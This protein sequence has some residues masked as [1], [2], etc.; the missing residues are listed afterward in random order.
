MMCNQAIPLPYLWMIYHQISF[1]N[2]GVAISQSSTATTQTEIPLVGVTKWQCENKLILNYFLIS[3][4]LSELSAICLCVAQLI[5]PT[6]SL[7]S[8]KLTPPLHKLQTP[9][10]K[11]TG[12]LSFSKTSSA[13]LSQSNSLAK[14]NESVVDLD[15]ARNVCWIG[16]EVSAKL[17]LKWFEVKVGKNATT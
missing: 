14:G 4:G 15:S 9:S 13:I 10:N 6:E 12:L 8:A 1:L 16:L 17:N 7:S 2:E 3:Q 5:L 11:I